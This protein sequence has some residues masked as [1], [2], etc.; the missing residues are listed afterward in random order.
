MVRILHVAQPTD[1]GLAVH[2]ESLVEHECRIGWEV[3][4]ACPARGRLADEV[5]PHGATWH[6]WK[7]RW[8][9]VTLAWEWWSLQR[10]IREV[11]PDVIHL[12]SSK[13]GLVGR[14]PI[15]AARPVAFT[16][17]GWSFEVP[18]WTQRPARA[19]ERFAAKRTDLLIGVCDDERSRAQGIGISTDVVVIPN[20]VDVDPDSVLP[21]R[22][23]ARKELGLGDGPIAVCVGRLCKQKGQLDLAEN[24]HRV[25]RAVPGAELILVGGG[26]DRREIAALGAAGVRLVGRQDHNIATWLAAA[27]VG[28][29]PS[30]WEGMSYVTLETL[31]AGRQVVAFDASG[32]AE[33][34]GDCG[35]IVPLGEGMSAFV[36]AVSTMLHTD[37]GRGQEASARWQAA[38]FSRR[39][40]VMA[41]SEAVRCVLGG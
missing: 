38:K 12:H 26:P 24:W 15:R 11:R 30:S 39:Q 14:L 3:H 40:Q 28:V 41:T 36:S 9:P 32:M 1:F 17:N 33:A 13:A 34:I 29:Q 35:T 25:R 20:G 27:D 23:A 21:T 31:A 19:W 10:V 4:V 16:P 5:V 8:S 18:G 6:E 7:A 2:V 22:D 37:A